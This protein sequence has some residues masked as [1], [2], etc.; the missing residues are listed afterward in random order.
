MG[1]TSQIRRA[2]VLIPSTI[3]ESYGRN[4]KNDYL[5]FL[6]ISI[7]SLFELQTYLE[8]AKNLESIHKTRFDSL[9]LYHFEILNIKNA[10]RQ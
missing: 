1:I 3:A 2:S 7:S 8:I 10:K 4:E 6:N 5:R 9:K